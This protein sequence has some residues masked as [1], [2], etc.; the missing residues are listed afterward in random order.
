PPLAGL[1]DGDVPRHDQ[2]RLAGEVD[3]ACRDA[4]PLEL[5]DLREEDLRIDDAARTDH[6][7]LAAQHAARDLPDLVRLAV[8]DDRVTRVGP[9]LVAADEIGILRKQVDDLALPLISPL[10]ADYDCCWHSIEESNQDCGGRAVVLN[11]RASRARTSS[12]AAPASRPLGA[13][14]M[15]VAGTAPKG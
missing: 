7:R 14:T 9:A 4:T 12:Y 11:G 10:R 5:V 1:V 3:I 15:T 2:V 13:P 8:D 6:A